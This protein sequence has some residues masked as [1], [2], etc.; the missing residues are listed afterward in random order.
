M[1]LPLNITDLLNG[2]SVEWERTAPKAGWDP[3]RP[4]RLTAAV[5]GRLAFWGWPPR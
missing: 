5:P 4:E 1:P 2:N 3:G